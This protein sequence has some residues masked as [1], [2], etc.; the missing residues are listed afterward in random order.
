[1]ESAGPRKLRWL[2][3][4]ARAVDAAQNLTRPTLH[5][6]GCPARESKQKDPLRICT[7]DD[8]VRYSVGE[9]VR[10]A[11]S[12]AGDD[13]KRHTDVALLRSNAVLDRRTL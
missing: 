10:L 2:P 8:Q 4:R 1:M 3:H 5:F 11:G 12:R 6:R 13:Q 9:G 7:F